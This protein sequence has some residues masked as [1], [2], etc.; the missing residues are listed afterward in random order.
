M[1]KDQEMTP[2]E[3]RENARTVARKTL[4]NIDFQNIVS[5]GE[6]MNN[7]TLYGE[8]AATG[9][10]EAYDKGMTSESVRDIRKILQKEKKE[11]AERLGTYARP[12][13]SD[14]DVEANVIGQVNENKLLLPLGDLEE[15]VK[16]IS[17]GFG[18]E[19]EVPADLRD[20]NPQ[21]LQRKVQKVIREK[22]KKGETNVDPQKV[23]KEILDEK[24]IDAMAIYEGILSPAYTRGVALRAASRHYFTDFNTFGKRFIEKYKPKPAE[25][26]N[27][28]AREG[29]G[30]K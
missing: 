8:L 5:G 10:Q 20:Y 13:I 15:I 29:K 14:Y 12:S 6:I 11:E 19:F 23:A 24:E 7:Q 30:K 17:E 22:V 18:Y 9:G 2:E 25:E 4:E 16:G 26:E 21:E 28:E 27:S 3:I 1:E